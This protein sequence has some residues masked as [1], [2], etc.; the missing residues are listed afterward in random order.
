MYKLPRGWEFRRVDEVGE[1]Q[2][3]RQRSPSQTVGPYLRPYLRVAN[4]F[5]GYID[6]S[7]VL[8][9]NFTP[10]EFDTYSLSVGDILLNEGQDL[11]LVGR[12]AIYDGPPGVCFQN[13]LLRFRSQSVI[14]QFARTVFKYWLDQ[15]EF[16][17]LT[18]Q[19]TSIAHLGVGQF[20]TMKFP[21]APPLEQ[22]RIAD[23]LVNVDEQIDSATKIGSKLSVQMSG[24]LDQFVSED[25]SKGYSASIGDVLLRIDSGW[26]PLCDENPPSLDAWGVIKVSAVTSGRYLPAE[27]K[28]L[29]PG[30]RARSDIE[31]HDGDLIMCRANGARNLV[32]VAVMVIDTPP[33]LML[34][35]KTLR[36]VTDGALMSSRY[37]YY[38]I[39]SSYARR[40]I[41]ALLSGSSGQNNISQRL[42]RSM[43]ISV[44]G[45]VRQ[46]QVVRTIDALDA[47]IRTEAETLRMLQLLKQGLMHDLL[48]GRV[49]VTDG[50]LE[51]VGTE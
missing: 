1:V 42:I 26:S 37:L 8:Q 33:K 18:R 3:G 30:M 12:C 49:R 31:I 23:I 25:E 46:Q 16:R 36:L 48:M 20:S 35:D 21:F 45:H 17:M 29:L 44:P 22:R 5:D 39:T 2:L 13:T 51:R 43:R 4:V 15:G 27:S 47:R 28:T 6:Y 50:G 41:E 9:M 24:T 34:S 40:Q 32:G 38:F 11:D 19:T 7:D 10:R 14:P